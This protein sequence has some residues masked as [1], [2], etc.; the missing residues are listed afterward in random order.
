MVPSSLCGLCPLRAFASNRRTLPHNS[1]RPTEVTSNQNLRLAQTAYDLRQF[2]AARRLALAA[3]AD[4]D[5]GPAAFL[6][7]GN[8]ALKE[9]KFAE[10]RGHAENMLAIDPDSPAPHL[11]LGWSWLLD[12]N[13]DVPG[14]LTGPA[15]PR[16]GRAREAA[17][18]A[19]SLAPDFYLCYR[20]AATVEWEEGQHGLALQFVNQGLAL[21]PTDSDLLRCRGSLL[22]ELGQHDDANLALLQSLRAEPENP[23]AH[24]AMAKLQQ[25]TGHYRAA[26]LHVRELMRLS[27]DHREGATLYWELIKNRGHIEAGRS[28]SFPRPCVRLPR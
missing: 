15:R 13:S 4:D 12:I 28:E 7:L 3:L 10:A 23:T 21:E 18:E 16:I 8:V 1:F 20:L 19:L 2:A 6:I 25:A 11:L 27:P 14:N 22:C 26:I 17:R 5:Q 24:H 9:D